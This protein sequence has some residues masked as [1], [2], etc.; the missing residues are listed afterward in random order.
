MSKRAEELARDI[1][2]CLSPYYGG[3]IEDFSSF[4]SDKIDAPYFPS[5]PDALKGLREGS[6]AG[7]RLAMRAHK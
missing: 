1:F 3:N 7:N 5:V 2:R 6:K 4:Y